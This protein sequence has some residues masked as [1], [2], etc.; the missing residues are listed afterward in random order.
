[1]TSGAWPEVEAV[2]NLVSMSSWTTYSTWILGWVL[3]KAAVIVL[4]CCSPSPDQS[5]Q[6]FS[7]TTPSEDEEGEPE[8]AHP[9]VITVTARAAIASRLVR[10]A[11]I[12]GSFLS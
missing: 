11:C 9:V 4:N 3:L 12:G 2:R 6:N 1:M 10:V 5:P 8:E 7:R